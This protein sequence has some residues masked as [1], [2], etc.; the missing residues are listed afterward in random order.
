MA[1]KVRL[2]VRL[3]ESGLAKSRALAQA[4]ILSQ[5]V[6]VNGHVAQ[7]ASMSVDA[8]DE[9]TIKE[10]PPFVGRGGLKLKRALDAFSIDVH[11]LVCLDIGASTGGF[12]DCLLQSGAKRVYAVDVGYG[13]LDYSLRINPSVVVLERY[14]ARNLSVCDIEPV[15]FACADVSF[16]SLKHILH[17]M[18]RCLNTMSNVVVL[19]KPQFEAGRDKVQKG[20]IVRDVA[21]RADVCMDIMRY[22]QQCGFL[23]CGI[24][25]S[26]IKG[27][28]GNVEY[29]LWI[30]VDERKQD[31]QI[32]QSWVE[33]ITRI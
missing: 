9:L 22:A 12:T 25:P 19:I 3:V 30:Q 7:K 4:L 23:V 21:V 13:Q 16:I 8:S 14:N 33:R 31:D 17:P 24:E 27:A 20:G 2:D 28:K 29:L 10:K 11:G 5:E 15:S 32:L 6:L 1:D 18:Y 26:P